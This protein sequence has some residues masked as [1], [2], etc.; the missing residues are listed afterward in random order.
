MPRTVRAIAYASSYELEIPG[1]TENIPISGIEEVSAY[2]ETSKHN[3]GNK[4]K[5]QLN[6]PVSGPRQPGDAVFTAPVTTQNKLYE[7]YNKVNP[8]GGVGRDLSGNLKPP[9]LIIK[10]ADEDQILQIEMDDAFPFS[11]EW[12]DLDSSSAEI[13]GEKIT[14][15]CTDIDCM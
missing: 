13:T 9:S 2:V 7:W 15:K 6:K 4:A 11:V 3:I 1:E 12:T 5:E 10:G 14:I 8:V